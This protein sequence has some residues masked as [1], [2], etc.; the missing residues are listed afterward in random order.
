MNAAPPLSSAASRHALEERLGRVLAIHC[1]PV[2]GSAWWRERCAALG[3]DALR[4]VTSL[5]DLSRFGEMTSGD[6][7]ARPLKDYIPRCLHHRLSEFVVGQ[8]GGTTGGGVW[9]AYRSDEFEEAFVSP[10]VAAAAHVGFPRGET[11][12]FV[13]PG[14]PHIIAKA[15]RRLAQAT[16]SPDP[17]SV[18][19]DSRWAKVLPDG[20]F[21]QQRYL[22]HVVEQARQVIVTQDIG[23]VFATPAVL[24]PLAQTLTAAQRERVRGVHYGGMALAPDDLRALQVEHFPKAVH[25]SGYGNTLFGCCLELNTRAGRDLD[26]YP[27]GAR[28]LLEVV[29]EYGVA[30]PPGQAGTVRFTRLDESMLIVRMRERDEA[31]AVAVPPGGPDGFCLSGV[32]NPHTPRDTATNVAVG[33]Y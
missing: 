8:T 1:D 2:G 33:L 24:L 11:W 5:S 13:G 7:H 14:G 21:A 9:T 17:F 12:L 23:V 29:D 10:F 19:F 30:L 20:S 31:S 4:E 26:Y 16:A 22:A 25:L 18:D 28:L 32:R 15:A 6:L 27:C 3:I